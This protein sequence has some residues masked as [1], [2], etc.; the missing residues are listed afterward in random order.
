MADAGV[1]VCLGDSAA[2]WWGSFSLVAQH[3]YVDG[4]HK[5]G[6]RTAADAETHAGTAGTHKAPSGRRLHRVARA[7][8]QRT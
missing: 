3:T 2:R 4:P 6:S 8:L 1:H 7:V 5:L